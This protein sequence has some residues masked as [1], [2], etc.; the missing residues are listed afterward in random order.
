MSNKLTGGCYC[1]KIRYEISTEPIAVVHCHCN[2]CK[3]SVGSPFVTWA[4][5]DLKNLTY[6]KDTPVVYTTDTNAERGFC[7][8]CGSS[9]SYHK[10]GGD[11]IDITVGTFDDPNSVKPEKHIWDKRRI[12]WINFDDGLPHFSEWSAG[13]DPIESFI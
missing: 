5:F 10:I 12:H 3:R 4:V 13:Q 1:G 6:V 2:N 9:I 7:N 8:Q 11:S